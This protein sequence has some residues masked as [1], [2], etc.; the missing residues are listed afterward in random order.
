MRSI[1]CPILILA[2][3]VAAAAAPE[4]VHSVSVTGTAVTRVAPD[5]VSWNIAVW[6]QGELAQAKTRNEQKTQAVLDVIRRLGVAP[7][8][9][10]TD[11]LRVEQQYDQK[12]MPRRISIG[13]IV[14]RNITCK[15][16]DLARFDEFINQL[17]DMA[18]V[19][20]RYSLETSRYHEMRKE[21]RL[22]ALRL[23]KEKAEAMCNAVGETLGRVISMQEQQPAPY[24]SGRAGISNGSF[25]ASNAAFSEAGPTPAQDEVAEKSTMAPGLIEISESVN[26]SFEIGQ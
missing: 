10:Q 17:L 9:V 13:W 21:T 2:A 15:Q 22:N 12:M 23:A 25:A 11:Y 3:G 1:W 8:D 19:D 6:D 4:T 16:R 24:W 7:E 20:V 18:D 26:V 5:I 14:S